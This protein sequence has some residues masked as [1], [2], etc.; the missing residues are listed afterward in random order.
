MLASVQK[1]KDHPTDLN[2][3][4]MLHAARFITLG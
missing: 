1:T 2:K 3:L 4:A